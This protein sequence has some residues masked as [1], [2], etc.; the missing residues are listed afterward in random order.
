LELRIRRGVL[1][2][3]VEHAH[4]TA[5]A[6]CCGLL[7]G[8]DETIVEAVRAANVADDPARRFLVNPKDHIDGRRRARD[9]GL[10]VVG[11][12]HS[13]PASAA[14]PSATDVAEA[15]YADHLYLIVGLA[16]EPPE[17][18]LFRLEGGNFR[19]TPFVR[20]G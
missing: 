18:A 13:H 17:I 19:A 15:G 4:G 16:A 7:L 8:D 9:R 11:F 20:V 2:D 5:P 3:I 12:Y 1:D 14:E 6:E 10:A